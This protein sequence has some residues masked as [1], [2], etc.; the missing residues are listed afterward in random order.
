MP[1]KVS[2]ARKLRELIASG[3]TILVP[4]AHDPLFGRI[5]ERLGF[6]ACGCAGWMTGAHLTV[7]EPVMTMTEQIDVARKVAQAVS[8][9]VLSDGG[10]GYGEPVH[11]MRTVREFH[12]A[13]IAR[14]HIE[15]QIFPKRASY[16]RGLEHV[17]DYDEFMRRIEFALKARE[18]EGADILITGRT[19]AGNAVNGSW[20]EAGRRARGLKDLGV[21]GI[22]PMTRT[23][24]SMEKFRQE[25]PDDDILLATT[26]YFNGMHPEE[27]RKYGFQMISYPLATIISS[28]AG[29]IDLL[30]G[31]LETGIATYDREKAK[32]VREEIE[33]A[34]GL[35]D[36]WEV[37]KQTVEYDHRHLAGRQVAGYEGFDQKKEK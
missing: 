9:P 27:I 32:A 23:R 30:K 26:T 11:V 35:P 14:V 16:H 8:I 19:D 28:V 29:A 21:D 37:E 1:D 22:Q 24:D 5:I 36:L 31:V 2:P 15:D 12:R 20:K 7:P 34:I 25:F 3:E 6:K 10:T 33:N 18:E 4:G 13:G 17:C